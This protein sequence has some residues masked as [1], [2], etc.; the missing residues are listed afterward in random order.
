ME[1][2]E[3]K[4][5]WEQHIDPHILPLW[6]TLKSHGVSAEW[7]NPIVPGVRFFEE[8]NGSSRDVPEQE[9]YELVFLREQEELHTATQHQVALRTFLTMQIQAVSMKLRHL[10]LEF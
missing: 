7:R 4:K 3:L 2:D 6:E 1:L 9:F 10:G 8:I 5:S